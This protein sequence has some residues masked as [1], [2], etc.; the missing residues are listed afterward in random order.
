RRRGWARAG[1]APVGG[2]GRD[3]R[4]APFVRAPL[5]GSDA[6]AAPVI[7]GPTDA[8]RRELGAG[9]P[10]LYRYRPGTD[11]LAGGEGAF[12]PCSY[13]LAQALAR[14]GRLDE[15]AEVL[16]QLTSFENGLGLLPEEIDPTSRAYLGNFPQAF[17][18][19]AHV[20]AALE[21]RD[22]MAA[23]VRRRAGAVEARRL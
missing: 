4:D 18:H 1:G 15:A 20:A 23:R 2:K 5:L 10:L 13:W 6:P 22:G 8:T 16:E 3:D 17:T 9:G 21:I 11:G 19:A 7:H 14:M 12:L